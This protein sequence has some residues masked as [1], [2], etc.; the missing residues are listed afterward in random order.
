MHP[1]AAAL[2]RLKAQKPPRA[3]WSSLIVWGLLGA[4]LIWSWQGAEMN[5]G[6]LVEGAGN[7]ATLAD[8]FVPPDFT[9]W[10]FYVEEMVVTLQMAVWVHRRTA[11]DGRQFWAYSAKLSRS[12]LGKNGE[13]EITT[14]MREADLLE[15]AELCRAAREAIRQDQEWRR[16]AERAT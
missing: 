9:D 13:W 8:G 2:E 10:R 14:D 15:A 4:A 1:H 3:S 12:Y 5:P 7:M 16:A 11:G 6:A